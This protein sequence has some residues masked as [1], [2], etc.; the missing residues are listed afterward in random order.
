M[1]ERIGPLERARRWKQRGTLRDAYRHTFGDKSNVYGQ[2]VLRHLIKVGHIMEPTF[3]A[4][5]THETAEREGARRLVLSII[6]EANIN[7]EEFLRMIEEQQ[8]YGTE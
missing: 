1:P 3:V 6:R 7:E 5:D 8:Q 4:G 2:Q